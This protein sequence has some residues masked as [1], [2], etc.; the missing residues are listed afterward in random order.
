MFLMNKDNSISNDTLLG[1]DFDDQFGENEPSY[2]EGREGK[3][4]PK[5]LYLSLKRRSNALGWLE[6]R[7]FLA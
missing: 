3:Y 7:S 6:I 1:D 4:F 5:N 2:S